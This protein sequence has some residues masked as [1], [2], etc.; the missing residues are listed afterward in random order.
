[1]REKKTSQCRNSAVTPVP[2]C[3]QME[4]HHELSPDSTIHPTFSKMS[5]PVTYLYSYY[6]ITSKILSLMINSTES[7]H[8]RA[9]LPADITLQSCIDN[10]AAHW[11][12]WTEEFG[13]QLPLTPTP[14]ASL[15]TKQ[16]GREMRCHRSH[17]TAIGYN[18][19]PQTVPGNSHNVK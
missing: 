17:E 15:P 11:F 9:V 12:K 14:H 13:Q 19:H 3:P 8:N 5:I 10:R 1:M 2:P 7:M 18:T 16:R 4:F 6:H